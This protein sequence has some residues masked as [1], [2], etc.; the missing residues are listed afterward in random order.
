MAQ[1]ELGGFGR[2]D[3]RGVDVRRWDRARADNLYYTTTRNG[4]TWT[5]GTLDST[6]GHDPNRDGDDFEQQRRKVD[7]C[8]NGDLYAFDV[9]PWDNGGKGPWGSINPT[10]GAF[11]PIGNLVNAF[12]LNVGDFDESQGFSL[13][14]GPSGTLSRRDTDRTATLT[15]GHWT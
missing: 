4:T 6:W 14:F 11:T 15:S 8:A 1:T 9:A 3:F 2:A 10:T 7:V 12:P 5:F 13:A